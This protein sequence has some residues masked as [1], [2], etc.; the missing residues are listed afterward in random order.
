MKKKIHFFFSPKI[1]DFVQFFSLIYL[2]DFG[3]NNW[4]IDFWY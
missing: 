2:I 1:F 4:V 3:V